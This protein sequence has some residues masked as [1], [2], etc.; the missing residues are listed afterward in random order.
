MPISKRFEKTVIEVVH[1][2]KDK[3]SQIISVEFVIVNYFRPFAFYAMFIL[4]SIHNTYAL[5]H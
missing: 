5:P 2:E 1:S 4:I 3:V